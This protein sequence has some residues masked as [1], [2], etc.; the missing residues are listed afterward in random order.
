[1]EIVINQKTVKQQMQDILV[2][3]SWGD[4]ARIYFKKSPSWLYHKMNGIDGNGKRTDFTPEEIE[5]LKGAL[6]DLSQRI[7]KC[8]ETI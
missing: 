4:I 7:R 2:A 3:V 6:C 8:A 5:N 1:M